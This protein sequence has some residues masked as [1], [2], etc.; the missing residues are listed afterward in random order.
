MTQPWVEKLRRNPWIW[1]QGRRRHNGL[2]P[3]LR[4]YVT[5]RDGEPAKFHL[6]VESDG[7]AILL[8]NAS[9]A[10]RLSAEGAKIADQLLNAAKV[11]HASAGES[12]PNLGEDTELVNQVRLVIDR[13]GKRSARFPIINLLDPRIAPEASEALMWPLM[14]D[15]VVGATDT[16][17]IVLEQCWQGGIPHARLLVNESIRSDDLAR[18]VTRAEDLG[19]ITGVR[20]ARCEVFT[21]ELI[22]ATAAAGLDYI[23]VPYIPSAALHEVVYGRGDHEKF[24]DVIEEAQRHELAIVVEIPLV[25]ESMTTMEEGLDRLLRRSI[26]NLELFVLGIPDS[27]PRELD[28]GQ[29]IHGLYGREVRQ[30]A[31]SWEDYAVQHH[32]NMMWLVPQAW[33]PHRSLSEQIVAGPRCSSEASFRVGTNGEVWMAGHEPLPLANLLQEGWSSALKRWAKVENQTQ[34]AKDF[35]PCDACPNLAICLRRCPADAA[36]WD[37]APESK[38]SAGVNTA[39]RG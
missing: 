9:E 11:V 34:S 15:V 21:S 22:Q 17:S 39:S 28:D 13:L 2:S 33:Q 27:L 5:A 24:G 12:P 18:I 19:M 38:L 32:L 23:V 8:C 3:G 10:V 25:Y 1:P 37:V 31:T 6:R 29:P 26:Q 16:T 14:A 4:S 30:V 20:G 35:R 36:C 7:S